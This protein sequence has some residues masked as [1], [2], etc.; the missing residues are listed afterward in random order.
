MKRAH[1]L[2]TGAALA[3]ILAIPS[4]ARA[5][6]TMGGPP[7]TPGSPPKPPA[8]STPASA[9]RG[10]RPEVNLSVGVRGMVLQ[11]AGFDPYA[12]SD[13]LGQASLS[14]GITALSLGRTSI[15]AAAE[16]DFGR[17]QA[18]ARGERTS[19][20][21]H[22]LGGFVEARFQVVRRLHLLV[23]VAPAAYHLRGSIETSVVD[24][25]LVSRTWTWGL[26]TTGGVGFMFASTGPREAPTSRFWFTFEAGYAFAGKSAMR[27]A[28][29]SRDDDPRTF[30]PVELPALSPSG[31]VGRIGMAVAF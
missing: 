1:S 28:P 20:G 23:K 17:R 27:Y 29:A 4:I 12:S 10:G 19:L 11:G 5:E 16:W 14:A 9:P 25:P 7:G 15:V 3:A 22:R 30:G 13:L 6:S 8:E 21:V 24:R 18:T 2:C 26:D 31:A